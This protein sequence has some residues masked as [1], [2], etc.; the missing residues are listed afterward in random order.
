MALRVGINALFLI[1]GG[2]GG[3]EIYLRFILQALSRIDPGT[4]YVVFL[5]RE[6][7]LD[8]LPSSPGFHAVRCN[9]AA[10]FRPSRIIFEQ[11]NL[12]PL[13]DRH[14]VDVLLNP[15]FTAPLRARCPQVTVFHDLQHKVHPEFFRARDLPFWNLL[16]AASA[17]RS[18]RL[19]AVSANTAGDLAEKLPQS[20]GKIAVIPHGVDREFFRIG[21]ERRERPARPYI[22]T[23][24]T[25]HPHKNIERAIDAFRRV[26]SAHDAFQFVI[27]GLKGFATERLERRV[28]EQG[29]AAHVHLTGWIPRSELYDLYAGAS[30][31]F[32][33]SLFEGFGM[34]LVE[35]MAAGLPVACSDIAPFRET[36]KGVVRMFDPRS[37]EDMTQALAFILHDGEFRARA[38]VEGPRRA[39]RFDWDIAARATLAELKAAADLTRPARENTR[40]TDAP[41]APR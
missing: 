28:R 17:S 11:V 6:T 18:S 15:G 27:A 5:N 7:G 39:S 2:V 38:A 40:E 37:T 9:V 10:R 21:H 24:S 34:P 35:A 29:L 23:V 1:P 41:L 22:L 19:I 16:L 30:A 25:L 12:P 4:E 20:K 33:P 36:A 14:R 13:L 8:L 32:A 3:T 26:H 31:F